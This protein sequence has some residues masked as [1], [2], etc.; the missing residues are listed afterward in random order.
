M[1]IDP[2]QAKAGWPGTRTVLPEAPVSREGSEQAP[3]TSPG[4]ISPRLEMLHR[5]MA[6]LRFVPHLQ[7]SKAK[8]SSYSSSSLLQRQEMCRQVPGEAAAPRIC[9]GQRCREGRRG[10]C[11]AAVGCSPRAAWGSWTRAKCPDTKVQR[12]NSP[13]QALEQR[14]EQKSHRVEEEKPSEPGK[15]LLALLTFPILI[16]LMTP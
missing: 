3:G 8:P 2:R 4:Q 5:A 7:P 13:C 10:S 1:L 9:G 12:L 11:P 16:A 14:W 15:Q 6:A